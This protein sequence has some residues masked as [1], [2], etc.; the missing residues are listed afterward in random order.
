[1]FGSTSVS[2]ASQY[3]HPDYLSPLPTTLD[4]KK[5]PLALLA[6]TCNSIGKDISPGRPVLK[7]TTSSSSSKESKDKDSRTTR[8]SPWISRDHGSKVKDEAENSERPIIGSPVADSKSEE[9]ESTTVQTS[10]SSSTGSSRCCSDGHRSGPTPVGHGKSSTPVAASTSSS[11]LDHRHSTVSNR[12]FS[13]KEKTGPRS[14][15]Q[16]VRSV[17][18][19]SSSPK[20]DLSR[21]PEEVWL[22]RSVTSSPKTNRFSVVDGDLGSSTHKTDHKPTRHPAPSP[23]TTSEPFAHFRQTTSSTSPAT[24]DCLSPLVLS[25]LTGMPQYA[26]H[27][28]PPGSMDPLTTKFPSTSLSAYLAYLQSRGGLAPCKDPFC[29][30]CPAAPQPPPLSFPSMALFDKTLTGP[31]LRPPYALP[32][33]DRPCPTG[34]ASLEALSALYA[35]SL[36]GSALS[37]PALPGAWTCPW[38]TTEG[39]YC[40]KRCASAE[41]LLV[42]TRSHWPSSRISPPPSLHS[43][44]AG[45]SGWIGY[46]PYYPFGPSVSSMALLRHAYGGGAARNLSPAT[47]LFSLGASGSRYH[48]YKSPPTSVSLSSPSSSFDLYSNQRTMGAAAP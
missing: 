2:S 24:G 12:K 33:H 3:L 38:V 13:P 39:E 10:T 48:P 20:K 4:A 31:N 1:M 5:S 34:P 37:P 6:Q 46:H 42:H 7:T 29:T 16:S 14:A 8:D 23:G 30:E 22:D 11:C 36:G 43:V 17:V 47:G 15:S 21:E 40:G 28:L 9:S 45:L 26:G 19:S 44:A 18:A 32:L 27:L 41:E 35:G 25:Y